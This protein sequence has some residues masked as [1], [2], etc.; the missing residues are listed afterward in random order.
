M[1]AKL[2]RFDASRRRLPAA[3]PVHHNDNHRD[4]RRDRGCLAAARPQARRQRLVCRWRVNAVGRLESHWVT[5]PVEE[6]EA[7]QRRFRIGR[8]PA[9]TAGDLVRG[10]VSLGRAA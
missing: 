7:P 2:A 5:E 6:I 10:E 9:N 4:N 8:T 3:A 1:F